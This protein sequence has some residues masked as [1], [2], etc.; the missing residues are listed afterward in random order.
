M[1]GGHDLPAK[2][3][4]GPGSEKPIWDGATKAVFVPDPSDVGLGPALHDAPTLTASAPSLLLS[5][6]RP[7]RSA[8]AIP[9]TAPRAITFAFRACCKPPNVIE[10]YGV[11]R[12]NAT[13]SWR[14]AFG[15]RERIIL[16][17]SSSPHGQRAA[18]AKA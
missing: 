12:A 9:S 8:P 2:F 7:E 4:L 5:R 10:N 13:E 3:R 11:S 18:K 17:R 16:L 15:H 1:T 14:T 6:A